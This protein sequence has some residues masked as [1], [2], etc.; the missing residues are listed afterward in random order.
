MFHNL[1]KLHNVPNYHKYNLYLPLLHI[2]MIN[3]L[4]NRYYYP[5]YC[6]Q[7]LQSIYQIDNFL[8]HY[9]RYLMK[10]KAQRYVILYM[11]SS[12]DNIQLNYF[13]LLL[14][15]HLPLLILNQKKEQCHDYMMHPNLR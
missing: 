2:H 12:H 14:Y 4:H 6:H 11:I 3:I 15:Q 9:K 10:V 13:D 8:I 5:H 1:N 7:V